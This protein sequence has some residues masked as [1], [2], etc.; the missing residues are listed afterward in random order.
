MSASHLMAATMNMAAGNDSPQR[1][2]RTVANVLMG[3]G[4]GIAAIILIIIGFKVLVRTSSSR[5]A[6]ADGGNGL[7]DAFQEV[8]HVLVGLFFI[9][10][11]FFIVGVI[12]VIV[13]SLSK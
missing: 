9:T 6:G 13:D 4:G 12:G 2:L 7:R 10:G 3:F 11:A 5:R 8:G 1:F